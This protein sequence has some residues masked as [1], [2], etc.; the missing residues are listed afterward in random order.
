M[1]LSWFLSNLLSAKVAEEPS[2]CPKLGAGWLVWRPR[3][4][5]K[6]RRGVWGVGGRLSDRVGR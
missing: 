4:R 6:I 1:I 5:S 3:G 2:R